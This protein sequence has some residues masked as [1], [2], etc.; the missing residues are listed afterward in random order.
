MP[1]RRDPLKEQLDSLAALREQP[2][3]RRDEPAYEARQSLLRS[4]LTARSSFAVAAAAEH[5][6][7]SDTELL[8]LLPHTFERF[9]SGAEQSDKGCSAKTAIAR[10][11]ERVES[12]EETVFRRGLLHVQREPVF[13]GRQ[14]TAVELRGT[15]ALGLARLSP[16]DVL[17]LLA[18]LLADSEH[19]A[20]TAAAR[21][22]GC[23]GQAGAAPLLR[24][25]A[26]VGDDEPLVLAECL[27][28]LL[29]LE[30]AAA[31]P[32][33]Q[34]FL[35]P[36]DEQR[37]DA[38]ALALGQSRLPEAV[39][40]LKEYADAPPRARRKAALVALAMLRRPEATEHLLELVREAEPGQAALAVEALALNRHDAALHRQ[41]AQS[42]AERRSAVL[43]TALARA[44]GPAAP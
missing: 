22:L 27:T 5:L 15:C 24:F 2:L 4:A 19:G 30:Q 38:A 20:R 11:L 8:A 10:A 40:L 41:V 34:R 16:P 12:D 39:P 18:E 28:S 31:I 23:T 6:R 37:G 33:V 35:L 36:E 13:G 7:E 17:T 44:F 43:S 29:G 21:A 26:L 3:P 42:V 14:D 25:K 1:P 32:F 9:L